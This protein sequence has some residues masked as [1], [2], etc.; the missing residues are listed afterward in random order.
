MLGRTSSAFSRCERSAVDPFA[1]PASPTVASQRSGGR[2][3][4]VDVTTE[5]PGSRRRLNRWH[6][7]EAQRQASAAPPMV[8]CRK[9]RRNCRCHCRTADRVHVWNGSTRKPTDQC[10][11]RAPARCNACRHG[12]QQTIL[13]AMAFGWCRRP[14]IMTRGSHSEFRA[15][16]RPTP[17]LNATLRSKVPVSG[18]RCQAPE[19][20]GQRSGHRAGGDDTLEQRVLVLSSTGAI[21]RCRW[22][23]RRRS[24]LTVKKAC[25]TGS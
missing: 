25:W 23:A 18:Q 4:V 19:I 8:G 9:R 15:N 7:A 1:R 11:S 13:D 14:K 5:V 22:S 17:E 2:N 10:R 16:D 12:I 6:E 21:Q 20:D 24:P 3:V